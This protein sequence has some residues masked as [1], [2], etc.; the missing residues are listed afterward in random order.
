MRHISYK[1]NPGSG[2]LQHIGDDFTTAGTSASK[3]VFNALRIS[4]GLSLEYGSSNL[5]R[6]PG[7]LLPELTQ[8]FSVTACRRKQRLLPTNS[9]LVVV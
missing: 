3:A 1:G 5:L 8:F 2:A 9:A 7:K 6:D 4:S